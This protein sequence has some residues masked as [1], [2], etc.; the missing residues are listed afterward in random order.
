M[1]ALVFAQSGDRASVTR[2]LLSVTGPV[3]V[4]TIVNVAVPP[5]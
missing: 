4:T 2:T 3:F 5:S 1:L